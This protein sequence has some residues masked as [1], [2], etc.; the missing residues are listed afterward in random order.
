MNTTVEDGRFTISFPNLEQ[1]YKE[2]DAVESTGDAYEWKKN[3]EGDN[4]Y[5]IGL[6]RDEIIKSK[7]CYKEGLDKLESIEQDFNLGGSKRIYKWDENDGDD[8]D[9]DRFL[10]NLPCLSKRTI[11]KGDGKGKIITIY[12]SIG[13]NCNVRYQEMLNRSYTVMRLVDY[14]ENLNYRT[15]IIVYM[16]VE[17]LGK[18]KEERIERLHTEIIL[19]RAEDPLIKG[20]ILNCISPWML[21]Y[22]MFKFWCAK[23]RVNSGYGHSYTPVYVNTNNKI[24]FRTGECLNEKSCKAYLKELAKKF[25]FDE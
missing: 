9:Y 13:E 3:N 6:S 8:M 4:P 11:K 1:F 18:Y 2:S 7:F 12:V 16:D 15:E 23:F 20:L 21:R 17:G 19:K 22:H 25:N 14:L 10:D 5:W 24:Y